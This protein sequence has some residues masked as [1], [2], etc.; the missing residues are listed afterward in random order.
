MG[1]SEK[2]EQQRGEEH[3]IANTIKNNNTVC[4]NIYKR[5][6]NIKLSNIKK[7]VHTKNSK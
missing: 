3:D 5:K 1:E 7:D 6:L 4:L 2:D